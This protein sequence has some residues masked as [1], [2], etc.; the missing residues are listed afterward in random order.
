MDCSRSPHLVAFVG[1]VLPIPTR[2]FEGEPS[3]S[4]ILAKGIQSKLAIP[5]AS[6]SCLIF[7]DRLNHCKDLCL[8]GQWQ[9]PPSLDHQ[10][11][12]KIRQSIDAR[13]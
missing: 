3:G 10:G 8:D 1:L 2:E 6:L 13:Q 12:A 4:P 5:R 7:T 9:A 11:K